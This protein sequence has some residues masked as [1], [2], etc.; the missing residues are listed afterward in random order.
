MPKR[1]RFTPS[2]PVIFSKMSID[3]DGVVRGGVLSSAGLASGLA[4]NLFLQNFQRSSAFLRTC[5]QV[6][7]EGRSILYSE[8]EFFF[9]RQSR[10]CGSI[11]AADW[12]E[13]G[14]KPVRKFLKMIG[15]QG[16]AP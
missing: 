7:D 10:R 9:Q 5:R 2:M 4:R 15:R 12:G 13:L 6:Y 8:N 1:L 16:L 3:S 11:W 14:F